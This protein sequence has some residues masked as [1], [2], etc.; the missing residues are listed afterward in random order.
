MT[1]VLKLYGDDDD[2]GAAIAKAVERLAPTARGVWTLD[3]ADPVRFNP[4]EPVEVSDE[5]KEAWM[6]ADRERIAREQ[7]ETIANRVEPLDG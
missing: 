1:W 2:E 4:P 6:A 5:E 7:A 3:G